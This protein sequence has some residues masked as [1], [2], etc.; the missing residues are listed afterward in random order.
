MAEN[1]TIKTLKD[2]RE[3]TL[4]GNRDRFFFP[5]EWFKF[6]DCLKKKQ[7]FTFGFLLNTGARINEARNVRVDD[8]DLERKRIVL[9]VTK[10]KA[11]KKEKSPRPRIIPVSTQY[12]K[13]LKAHIKL[14]NLGNDAYLGV[15]STP[16]ANI[17]MKKALRKAGVKD[18][19]M[20]S[21]HN[22]RKTLECWLMALGVDGLKIVA[23]IGHSMQVA[24]QNYISADVFSWEE[25]RQ[26]RM[27]LGDL[28]QR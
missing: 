26:M 13:K 3:Y 23:H 6:Y 20:F 5:H 8:I 2:G 12:A 16:A 22:V 7:Q 18:W 11:A 25:K 28:Y 19:Q 21:V 9:R 4:R 14:H 27:I 17:G 15:L 10:V 24:A 1:F